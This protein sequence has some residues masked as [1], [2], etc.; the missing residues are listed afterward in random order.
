[1]AFLAMDFFF[2]LVSLQCLYHQGEFVF[3]PD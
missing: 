1:M 2:F 3:K